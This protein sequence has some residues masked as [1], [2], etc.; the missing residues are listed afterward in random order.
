M[1]INLTMKSLKSIRMKMD[2]LKSLFLPLFFLS[3]ASTPPYP[4]PAG[5]NAWNERQLFIPVDM[6]D[7]NNWLRDVRGDDSQFLTVAI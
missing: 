7:F 3:S 6:F 2:V 4:I 1:V 5:E